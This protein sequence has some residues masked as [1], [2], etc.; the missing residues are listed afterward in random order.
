MKIVNIYTDG[1][2][3]GNQNENNKGGWGC[4]LEFSGIEKELSGGEK[5]TTNNRME[6]TALIAGL[7]ALKEKG[8]QLRI[9]SDSSYLVNCFKNRWYVNWQNNGWKTAAKAPVE[10]RDLW[11]Q[12]LELLQGQQY[13]FYLVKGHLPADASQ[14]KLHKA[15][16]KF[17]EHNGPF[18]FEEFRLVVTYNNRCDKLATEAAAAL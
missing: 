1:A 16:E 8:L 18:D 10:N 2:C 9:F 7:S 17:Q 12:L 5:N 13:A 3:S 11:M 6:L 4:V 14:D 15:Y